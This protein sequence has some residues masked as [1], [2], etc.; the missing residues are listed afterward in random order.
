MLDTPGLLGVESSTLIYH[1]N[2]EFFERIVLG[3]SPLSMSEGQAFVVVRP[4]GTPN[5]EVTR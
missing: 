1:Q 2:M 5:G 4:S 3:K